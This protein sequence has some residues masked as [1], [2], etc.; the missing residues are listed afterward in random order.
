VGRQNST[1]AE[2][3]SSPAAEN[4]NMK[5]YGDLLDGLE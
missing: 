2:A 4:K 3:A 5:K 1:A